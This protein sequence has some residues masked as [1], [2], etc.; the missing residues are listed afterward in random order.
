MLSGYYL[1]AEAKSLWSAGRYPVEV[2]MVPHT[3][4]CNRGGRLQT[5]S[6]GQAG[7]LHGVSGS[8]AKARKNT[9]SNGSYHA[10]TDAMLLRSSFRLRNAVGHTSQDRRA[11]AARSAD[12]PSA[13]IMTSHS[14]VSSSDIA[15]STCAHTQQQA[16]NSQQPANQVVLC[17]RC[18][19]EAPM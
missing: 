4:D 12:P 2:K 13:E 16:A 18:P 9:L 1:M 7:S 5:L 17:T 10:T 3:V 6:L 15:L 14:D 8:C 11:A 19:L